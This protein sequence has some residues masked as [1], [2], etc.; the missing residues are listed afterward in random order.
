MERI[1]YHDLIGLLEGG[2]YVALRG[3]LIEMNA[4][5]V[6][7]FMT[8]LDP[9]QRILVFRLLPK[10]L[11]A[12]AFAY[13]DSDLQADIVTSISNRE[14]YTLVDGL[15]IDDT[16]DF[17]DEV[18]A[19][20]VRRVMTVAAPQ[21]RELINKFL[22]YPENSAGSVM[23]SEMIELHDRCTVAQAM[24][25]IRRSGEDRETIYTCYCISDS[26]RL[27]GTVELRDLIFH[28]PDEF[29]RD[30]MDADESLIRVNTHDDQETVADLARRYDLLSVPVTDNEGRLVGIV[31]I[32]DIV[33]IIEAENTEDFERMALMQP[34]EDT[35]LRTGVLSMYKNRI[36]WLAILMVSAT[37]TGKIIEGFESK[38]ALVAGLTAAIPMLMDTGGNSGS[39]ASTLIIRGL[40]LGEVKLRDW[41][42]VLWKELR[43]SLLCG[44]TLAVL[45]F[46]RMWLLGT[47]NLL[48]IL[49]VCAAMLSAVVFSKLVGSSLPLAAKFLR[50]DPALMAGP[51]ITTIVDA[52]TLLIYFALAQVFLF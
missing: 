45:N 5:D 47:R 39:Q 50:L 51:M 44:T 11:S 42:R 19:S 46:A 12:D 1:L 37:F 23:T 4:V 35:Y 14:L 30:I 21:T 10:D 8:L 6:A 16:V 38:L 52:V 17:L 15:Y 2:E 7:E 20:V 34:S 13:L 48:M 31:T 22:A 36:L 27:V 28:E 49:V 3:Q 9:A 26:R 32:D 41:F 25:E 43:V 33:D 40:A 24:A 29:L 18:P